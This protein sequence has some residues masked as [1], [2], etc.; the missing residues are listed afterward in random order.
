MD[1][2][3]LRI[4]HVNLI[5]TFLLRKRYC[6]YVQFGTIWLL[7]AKPVV[8]VAAAGQTSRRTTHAS[9]AAALGRMFRSG[10]LQSLTI[11]QF[12]IYLRITT[13]SKIH[14]E[15]T[16]HPSLLSLFHP[17]NTTEWIV[18]L[19]GLSSINCL[20][21]YEFIYE[22]RYLRNEFLPFIVVST[23]LK[24]PTG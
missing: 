23:P 17:S 15:S 19:L 12:H 7:F 13:K 11:N 5:I 4:H 18:D 9:D 16:T 8:G 1:I 6:T 21:H 10:S 2:L 24:D 14:V 22:S 3:A 20:G